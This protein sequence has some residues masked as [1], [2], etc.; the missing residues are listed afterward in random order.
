MS[1]ENIITTGIVTVLGVVLGFLGGRATRP[2]RTVRSDL[3][4]RYLRTQRA[5]HDL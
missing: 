1:I 5:T 2:T 3:P 4:A